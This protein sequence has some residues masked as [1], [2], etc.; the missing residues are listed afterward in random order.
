MTAGT[1]SP[2]RPTVTLWVLLGA[3][4]FLLASL[5][6]GALRRPVPA[7][8][9]VTA[10]TPA[11]VGD[12]L[13]GPAVYTVDATDEFQWTFFDFS[14]NAVVAA[15]GPLDWDLAFRRFVIIANG[16]AG[17]AGQGGVVDLGVPF[18]SVREAP[19]TG[20]APTAR[21]STNPGIGHWYKYGYSSHLLDPGG[22]T[23]VVRTADGH[24]AKFSIVGYYCREVRSGCFTIRYAYQGDGT[25]T[26]TRVPSPRR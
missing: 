17:F 12:S 24:Y 23:Y 14:R 2:F 22:H 16:G 3:F 11:S 26:L 13:V 15:P 9:D 4:G 8:A 25:R 18:D 6:V 1:P 20:Y 21:D 5:V 7:A 19:D 10:P